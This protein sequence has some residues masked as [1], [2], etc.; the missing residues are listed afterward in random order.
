M[1]S[2][3]AVSLFRNPKWEYHFWLP[4][5]RPGWM[6]LVLAHYQLPRRLQHLPWGK[7]QISSKCLKKRLKKPPKKPFCKDIFQS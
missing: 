3:S 7:T 6:R 1:S 2:N 5:R 4:A